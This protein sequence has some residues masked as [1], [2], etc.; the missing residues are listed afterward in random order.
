MCHDLFAH[1]LPECSSCYPE[2]CPIPLGSAKRAAWYVN[3]AL[4]VHRCRFFPIR[5]RRRWKRR[6]L[7]IPYQ[8]ERQIQRIIPM[9]VTASRIAHCSSR[10][11]HRASLDSKVRCQI[12][13][14]RDLVVDPNHH[15]NM[16]R[17][18]LR[19]CVAGK[20]YLNVMHQVS[21]INAYIGTCCP[22]AVDNALQAWNDFSSLIIFEF[23]G[24][25]R[26]LLAVSR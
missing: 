26:C 5:S 11:A 7:S 15:D 4:C 22:N 9:L 2:D 1:R 12:R 13:A 16:D 6:Q 10:I 8:L 23:L 14:R 24:G 17:D 19:P 3:C 21:V 20:F 18:A 25:M